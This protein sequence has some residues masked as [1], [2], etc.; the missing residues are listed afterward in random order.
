MIGRL[1]SNGAASLR[2][3]S[4]SVR[5]GMDWASVIGRCQPE[6][7][8]TIVELRTRHNELWR[9]LSEAESATRPI[10]FASYRER[11]RKAYDDIDESGD[12]A[13][14]D[15]AFVDKAEFELS[16][17]AVSNESIVAEQ[18][19]SL[20]AERQKKVSFIRP[21]SSAFDN[22]FSIFAGV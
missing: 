15:L 12:A 22:R 14:Q 2:K 6:A 8:Q 7:R 9:L 10:D 5:E 16:N 19:T 1:F 20:E 3:L 4:S 18:Q 21:N 11:I 17:Y 13:F